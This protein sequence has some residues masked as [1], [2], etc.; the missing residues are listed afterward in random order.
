ME[1][2][3]HR[4]A[5]R[6]NVFLGI[7]GRLSTV[8]VLGALAMALVG[9]VF[10][11]IVGT[12]LGFA[13]T[14]AGIGAVWLALQALQSKMSDKDLGKT[15][16]GLRFGRSWVDTPRGVARDFLSD[17]EGPVATLND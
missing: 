12:F 1:A 10:G 17:G 15:L 13:V 8:L 11:K 5:D 9:F 7:R 2:K 4:S 6:P 16:T 14:A 3:V